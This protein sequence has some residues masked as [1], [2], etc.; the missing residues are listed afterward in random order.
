MNATAEKGIWQDV[1]KNGA[2]V[3][4]DTNHNIIRVKGVRGNPIK[5]E[6]DHDITITDYTQIK[7]S[8]EKADNPDKLHREATY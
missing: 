7:H 8:H 5:Y 3:T 4:I 6:F 2:I 1:L